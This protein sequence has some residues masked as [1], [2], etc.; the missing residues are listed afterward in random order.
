MSYYIRSSGREATF[1][2]SSTGAKLTGKQKGLEP[3]TLKRSLAG[4][5]SYEIITVNG[6][7]DVVEHRRMEPYFFMTD[8]PAVW[9][10][11][12]VPANNAF[13]SDGAR[14]R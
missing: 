4:Y 8:D 13:H 9:S 6:V 12:G 14:G 5:P 10:E 7:T 3:L 11:L 1:E 2:C